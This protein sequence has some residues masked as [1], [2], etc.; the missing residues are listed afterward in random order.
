MKRLLRLSMPVAVI[1]LLLWAFGASEIGARLRG[2]AWP[3]LAMAV[4]CLLGQTVLM[5]LRWRLVAACLGLRFG[6]GWAMREYLIGQVI[7]LTLPGGVLGDAGRAVRSRGGAGMARA[8]QAVVIERAAGQAG[9]LAV[10][11]LGLV[12]AVA[13]PGSLDWP[14]GAEP[15]V[16]LAAGMAIVIIAAMAL[17]GGRITALIRLCLPTRRIAAMQVALSIG[18]AVLNIAGFWACARATG[19]VLAPQVAL[20]LVP[21]ILTAMLI[22]FGVGGWGWREGAAAVLF[23]VAGAAAEAGIAAGIAF[24]A[25][26]LLS[27]LP[28]LA[29]GPGAL[30]GAVR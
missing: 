4:A 22:P 18:A 27:V 30:R 8:A 6:R 7:N 15:W 13:V 12:W 29:F 9:L 23:P 24:G 2:V 5:A 10:G 25:A 19:T 26:M 21:A 14:P 16:G 11:L 20:V 28:I 1:G 17:R 3:W